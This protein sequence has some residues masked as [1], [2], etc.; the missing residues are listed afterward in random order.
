M[1]N[2][3]RAVQIS[4]PLAAGLALW[5]GHAQATP[6]GPLAVLSARLQ[7]APLS[8]NSKNLSTFLAPTPAMSALTKTRKR[9]AGI[10]APAKR[11]RIDPLTTLPPASKNRSSMQIRGL[12]R[13]LGK[14]ASQ[15]SASKQ[16]DPQLSAMP[17]W[18]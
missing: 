18:K 17:N 8:S 12:A 6:V 15:N 16:L 2:F 14:D 7:S 3:L 5:G 1:K 4:L 9:L 13:H 11:L 10:D